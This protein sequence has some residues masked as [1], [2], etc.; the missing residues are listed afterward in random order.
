MAAKMKGF[1]RPVKEKVEEDAFG[2]ASDSDAELNESQEQDNDSEV[3]D[4]IDTDMIKVNDSKLM[5]NKLVKSDF[6]EL[7]S[8]CAGLDAE[9]QEV[10]SP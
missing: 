7:S 9:A 4:Q 5:Q 10:K 6:D 2:F 3:K 8:L 1:A